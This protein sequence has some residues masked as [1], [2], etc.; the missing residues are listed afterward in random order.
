MRPA[1]SRELAGTLECQISNLADEIA[2]N[3]ADLEDGLRS[4]VLDYLEVR[5]LGVWQIVMAVAR[6]DGPT[7]GWTISCAPASSAG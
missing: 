4:G 5:E 3:T 2:Y 6:R 7:A 1:T